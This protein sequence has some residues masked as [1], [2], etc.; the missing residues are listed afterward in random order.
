MREVQDF[1]DL[2]G[3]QLRDKIMSKFQTS[4]F[5]A[6][7]A[8]AVLGVQLSDLGSASQP[9]PPL[10]AVSVALMFGA[11]LLYVAALIKL[12]ELTMPKRFWTTDER[13]ATDFTFVLLQDED[14]WELHK[15]MTFYWYTLTLAAT[16]ATA[17]ALLLLLV[18]PNWIP[19][20]P[21][22]GAEIRFVVVLAA[23]MLVVVYFLVLKAITQGRLNA[24][25]GNAR[26]NAMTKGRL[27][28]LENM[29]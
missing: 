9:R 18:P 13:V 23:V 7:L 8:V 3:D 26:L 6:G 21:E 14:L 11:L 20:A 29:Q 2:V 10:F 24:I 16:G 1:Y 28:R 22:M 27:K 5:L 17:F 12:D 19:G 4:A 25:T 15:R